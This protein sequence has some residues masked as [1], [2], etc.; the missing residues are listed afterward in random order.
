MA[1]AAR[2]NE[3]RVVVAGESSTGKSCF[4]CSITG[5]ILW[6][7]QPCV[8]PINVSQD[9][10]PDHGGPLT[11][12]DTSSELEDAGTV[13]EELKRADAVVLTYACDRPETFER[14]STHWLP[15]LRNLQVKVP[16]I[17]VGCKL[18]LKDENLEDRLRQLES[19]IKL[20]FPEVNDF[21]ETSVFEEILRRR[22]RVF[23]RA[24]QLVLFPPVDPLYDA[25]AGSLKPKV[26]KALERIFEECDQDKDGALND[27]ELNDFQVH[28]SWSPLQPDELANIKRFVEGRVSSGVNECG[29]TVG[30]F[31]ALHT[32]ILERGDPS[33]T[34]IALRS[35]GYNDAIE[36]ISQTP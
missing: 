7:P 36:L 22:P 16:V 30:G 25:E 13:A 5:A 4:I 11:I 21:V 20:Q 31:R 9:L 23:L 2:G 28:C 3:T 33:V 6:N 12:I 24:R 15:E 10:L 8:D 17:V 1:K 27:T 32:S 29:I 18:D 14:L 19:Q 35:F 26:T 34:W